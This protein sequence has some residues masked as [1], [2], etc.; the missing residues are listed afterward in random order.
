MR[1]FSDSARSDADASIRLTHDFRESDTSFAYGVVYQD[2]QTYQGTKFGGKVVLDNIYVMQ[3]V[4]NWLLYAGT[5]EQWWGPSGEQSHIMSNSARPYPKVGFK[6]IQT[7]A[8]DSKWLSWIGPW[9]IEANIGVQDGPRNDFQNPLLFAQ[10]FEAAP[11]KHFQIGL[12]RVNQLCGKT[13][14]CSANI[15]FKALLPVSG[16]VNTGISSTDFVN[17]VAAMD[18]SYARPVGNVVVSGYAQFF[19]EDS[20]FESISMMGGMTLTGHTQKFGQWRIG[21]EALDTYALRVFD[22]VDT[23]RQF[24]STYLNSVTYSDGYSYR[25]R[26]IGASVDGD[27]RLFSLFGSLTTDKNWHYSG[28][29]RYADINLFNTPN[30]RITRTREKIWIGEARRANF[31]T[32]AR[33]AQRSP[34]FWFFAESQWRAAWAGHRE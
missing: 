28:A 10:R 11:F 15:F 13:R 17:S 24:G 4:G 8:F 18:F 33:S 23:G 29:L 27:S 20:V 3:K 9:R 7:A 14:P 31:R 16:N 26:P 2:S 32:S 22:S 5:V 6:R 21:A 25:G 19:A 1:D 12:T 34:A 30:Y